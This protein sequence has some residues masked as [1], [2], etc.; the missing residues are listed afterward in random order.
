MKTIILG[1]MFSFGLVGVANADSVCDK[2]NYSVD[3]WFNYYKVPVA[4]YMANFV[5]G[6]YEGKDYEKQY[7]YYK[8]I[9]VV[10]YAKEFK[11]N[12]KESIC[13]YLL[14]TIDKSYLNTK[15]TPQDIEHFERWLVKNDEYESYESNKDGYLE[16]LKFL[17]YYNIA[18]QA[19][20]YK[21]QAGDSWW[22]SS[23]TSDLAKLTEK[24]GYMDF[25]RFVYGEKV[26]RVDF[27][28]KN[29]KELKGNSCES[30]ADTKEEAEQCKVLKPIVQWAESI[31]N[32]RKGAK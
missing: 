4:G 17:K 31:L 18:E 12:D 27:K 6:K 15:L 25:Y 16:A 21:N 23:L 8:S 7:E 13:A 24:H 1:L 14:T 20:K 9:F 29:V 19:Y 11:V 30:K 10:P 26:D 3:R 2:I 22:A 28:G 5:S 32:Q